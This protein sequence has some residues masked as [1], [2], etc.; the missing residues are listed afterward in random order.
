MS[1]TLETVL[2]ASVR[3]LAAAAGLS[4]SRMHQLGKLTV[5]KSIGEALPGSVASWAFSGCTRSGTQDHPVY[6][7]RAFRRPGRLLAAE[8]LF[9][10]SRHIV[11]DRPSRSVPWAEIPQLSTRDQRCP[12]AWQQYWQQ[13]RRNGLDPRP[14][15][16]QAPH[17]PSWRGSCESNA[18]SPVPAI[19]LRLLPLLSLLL[20]AAVR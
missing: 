1:E 16:F 20:P 7:P 4:P 2:R 17:I 14:S 3:T 15:A 6:I 9:R 12:A 11:Q 13:S 5:F 10:S 19:S 18:L 8:H